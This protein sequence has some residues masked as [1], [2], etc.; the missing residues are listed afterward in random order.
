MLR[1][2]YRGLHPL[3]RSDSDPT[4]SRD[5]AEARVTGSQRPPERLGLLLG[6][7]R[8]AQHTALGASTGEASEDAFPSQIAFELRK[9]PHQAERGTTGRARR[10][11]TFPAHK[12]VDASGV[13]V[14]ENAEQVGQAAAKRSTAVTATP[15]RTVA[16]SRP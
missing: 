1:T 13:Q 9:Q 6:Q 16:E 12:Q 2:A 15:D 8:S 14:A 7:S 10:V 3:H 5:L 4:P 11:Q